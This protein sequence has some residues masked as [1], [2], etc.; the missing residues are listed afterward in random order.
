MG[1]PLIPPKGEKCFSKFQKKLFPK[2]Y[3]PPTPFM[4]VTVL[5]TPYD[6]PVG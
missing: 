6:N 5:T 2:F 3:A 4:L 1:P